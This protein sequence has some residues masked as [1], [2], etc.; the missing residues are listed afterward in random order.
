M[1]QQPLMGQGLLIIEV[2]QSL[3]SLSTLKYSMYFLYTHNLVILCEVQGFHSGEAKNSIL[4]EWDTVS[5]G[6]QILMLQRQY[7]PL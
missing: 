2:S 4:L 3:W 7:V 1:T 6:N 5:Q